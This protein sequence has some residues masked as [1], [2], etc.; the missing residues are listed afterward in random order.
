MWVRVLPAGSVNCARAQLGCVHCSSDQFPAQVHFD[1]RVKLDLGVC[2][3]Y[4]SDERQRGSVMDHCDL[5]DGEHPVTV[6]GWTR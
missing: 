3:S 5:V 4:A 1:H 6:Q 2:L